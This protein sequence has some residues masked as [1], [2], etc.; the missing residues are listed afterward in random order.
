MKRQTE[1]FELDPNVDL[2]NYRFV[3]EELEALGTRLDAARAALEYATSDWARWYWKE[4]VD[5][6]LFQ[7][8]VKIAMY[9]SHGKDNS[10]PRWTVD[11]DWYE[12]DFY[13]HYG[14]SDRLFDK[15]FRTSLDESWERARNSRLNHCNCV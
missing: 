5:R 2:K 9:D 10:I 13:P 7:W 12:Q 11:Y 1:Q 6:L 4:A 14:V 8:Q 3:G 15:L